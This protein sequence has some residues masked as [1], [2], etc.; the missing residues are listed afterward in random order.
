MSFGTVTKVTEG[1]GNHA[2]VFLVNLTIVGDDAYPT[3][4]T[5]AFQDAVRAATGNEIEVMAV[6][7]NDCGGYIPNYDKT[8]DK[9]VV[10]EAGADAAALDEVT[11]TTDLSSTTF[12]LLILGK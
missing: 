6:V 5:A 1:G 9:L 7:G 11:D 10:Y 2:A 12:Q 8:N 4:G 3:G